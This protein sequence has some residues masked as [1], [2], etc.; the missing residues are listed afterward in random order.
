MIFLIT[1]RTVAPL[2]LRAVLHQG[3][4]RADEAARQKWE[5]PCWPQV[6]GPPEVTGEGATSPGFRTVTR[7]VTRL[8]QTAGPAR[9]GSIQPALSESLLKKRT[10]RWGVEWVSQ[11]VSG[12]Q[13]LAK[14]GGPPGGREDQAASG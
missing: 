12:D 3:P 7:P 1:L 13:R 8:G 10:S 14:M 4:K 11:G 5:R 6:H 9:E 2:W